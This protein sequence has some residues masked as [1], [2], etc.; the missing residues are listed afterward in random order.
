MNPVF[1]VRLKS[2]RKMMGWSLQDLADNLGIPIT[3][4]ALNKYESGQM[5]PGSD[6]LLALAK[7]LRVKPDYFLREPIELGPVEF[8]K[9]LKLQV[10]QQEQIKEQVR[11]F[12]ERYI[13]GETLLN[14]GIHFQNPLRE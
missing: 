5:K 3:K 4:Q 13:E 10:R 6:V 11:D 8:R 1:P 7:V 14:I 12:L 9:S 2:A